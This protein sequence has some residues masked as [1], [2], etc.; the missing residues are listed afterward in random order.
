[1]KGEGIRHLDARLPPDRLLQ[2]AWTELV[3]AAP[4]RFSVATG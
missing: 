2:A 4:Q 1:V 3:A